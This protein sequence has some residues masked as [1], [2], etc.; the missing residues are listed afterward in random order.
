MED[1]FVA[2][3]S[4]D[5]IFGHRHGGPYDRGSADRYYGRPFNPHYYKGDSYFSELVSM[6][7][8]TQDEITDYTNGWNE[9]WDRKEWR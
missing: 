3:A 1:T 4:P 2:A 7:D 8:M 9:E 5:I 6:E